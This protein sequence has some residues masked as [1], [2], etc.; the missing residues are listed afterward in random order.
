METPIE[1]E[2][3]KKPAPP[4]ITRPILW[5]LAAGVVLVLLPYVAAMA[6]VRHGF[7]FLTEDGPVWSYNASIMLLLP[8]VQGFVAGLA[9]GKWPK[10]GWA[11]VFSIW[12]F[13]NVAA[14]FILHEG[15]ICLIMASPLIWAGIGLAF[16][17]GRALTGWRSGTGASVS[18]AP[19]V[20]LAVLAETQG[21]TPNQADMVN[22]SIVIHAPADY[23]WKYVVAYPENPKAAD[24]WM[25]RLGLPAPVNSVAASP[26]V[27]AY[28]ECRFTGGQSYGERIT[29]VEPDRRL[30]YVVTRQM[31]HPEI[32]GHVSFDQGEIRLTPNADGSTTMTMTGWYR[33]HVRPAPYFALWSRDVSRHIHLRV[34]DYT[35]DLAERDYAHARAVKGGLPT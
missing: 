6:W 27:G 25:W 16:L 2:A 30:T 19:L 5:G 23:V 7:D 32:N 12:A 1:P 15:T 35:R 11:V 24:Y 13:D 33:L 34:L 29:A 9:R 31:A 10:G 21:P 26:E 18:L 22:D 17:L 14:I 20:L 4:T 3:D 8:L 28:R